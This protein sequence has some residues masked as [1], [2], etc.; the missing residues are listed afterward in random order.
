[1]GASKYF[2]PYKKKLNTPDQHKLQQ[3]NSR[4]PE[5]VP[6]LFSETENSDR[7]QSI[8]AEKKSCWHLQLGKKP[9]HWKGGGNF[10][11]GKIEFKRTGE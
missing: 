5:T 6:K 4:I 2:E 10:E 11:Y 1:M 3:Y 7:K 8:V 9:S